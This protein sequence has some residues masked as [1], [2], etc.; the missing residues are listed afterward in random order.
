MPQAD[1]IL[2]GTSFAGTIEPRQSK[3]TESAGFAASY[4]RY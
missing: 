3:S 2:G 1:P 4:L